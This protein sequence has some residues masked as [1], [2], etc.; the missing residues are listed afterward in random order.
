MK[1][2]TNMLAAA[3]LVLVAACAPKAESNES[4]ATETTTA[5]NNPADMAAVAQVRDAWLAGWKAANVAA[6]MALYAPD[7]HMMG[8]HM[9]T[10]SGTD[11]I[12]KA[13]TDQF[14]QITPGE[15]T[16]TSERQ[17]VAGDMAYDRG[18][19]SFTMTPKAP[20][21]KPITDTGRY[22][23]VLRKQA[24]GSWKLVEEFGNSATPLPNQ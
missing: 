20:N 17:E 22:V 18:T 15:A 14:S 8:N 1:R 19:Y 4:V 10:V 7:A 23:V 9:P 6:L 2:V 3:C 13:L 5:N 16:L 12:Q 21:A 24:D 11:A